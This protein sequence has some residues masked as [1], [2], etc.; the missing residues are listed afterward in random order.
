AADVPGELRV[1]LIDRDWPVFVPVGGRTSYLGDV[2]AIV[3][4]TQREIAR[5]A[6]TLVQV[7]YRPLP[8]IVDPIAAID[9]PEDAVWGVS[10][11]VLS[12][13]SYSRGQVDEA[14][15]LS[16]HTIHEVF[17]TQRV[18]HAFL[19]PESTLAVPQSD[20]RLL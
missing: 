12:R 2:L 7:T 1:G 13:C 10:G 11:N 16:T 9:D 4:A 17:Q 15:A 5:H 18:E 19:E 6:A 14:L 3:V 8:P 20:G